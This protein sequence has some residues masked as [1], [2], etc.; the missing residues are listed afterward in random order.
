MPGTAINSKK[1]IGSFSKEIFNQKNILYDINF[2]SQAE[3]EMRIM[4]RNF[5]QD[6]THNEESINFSNLE[7]SLNPSINL[8]VHH[9]PLT[10]DHHLF[11]QQ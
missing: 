5:P 1:N 7:S 8:D 11:L 4:A 3:R 10:R 2:S 9:P 6:S